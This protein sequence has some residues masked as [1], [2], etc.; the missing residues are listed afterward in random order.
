MKA[1]QPHTYGQS[2]LISHFFLCAL[3]SLELILLQDTVAL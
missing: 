2:R 1:V 3:S